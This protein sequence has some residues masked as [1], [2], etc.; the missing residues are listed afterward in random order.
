MSYLFSN[1][2]QRIAKEIQEYSALSQENQLSVINYINNAK[3]IADYWKELKPRALHASLKHYQ[4]HDLFNL[5]YSQPSFNNKN[6]AWASLLKNITKQLEFIKVK[7]YTEGD[8]EL[9]AL[10]TAR[11]MIRIL[12][13]MEKRQQ[14]QQQGQGQKQDQQGQDQ[15]DQIINAVKNELRASYQQIQEYKEGREEMQQLMMM[16]GNGGNGFSNDA[17]SLLK[18]LQSPD[19]LRQRIKILK[20]TFTWLRKFNTEL[21]ASFKK[22]QLASDQ[23]E[24]NR[25]EKLMKETQIT[26]MISG[27]YSYL[28]LARNNNLAKL[29][30]AMRYVNKELLVYRGSASPKAYLYIDKSGSMSEHLEGVPKISLAAGL[31]LAM[32]RKFSDT[33]VF[34]FDTE[35]T[36][37]DKN[38]IV[39]MLLTIS[40][41]GGTNI[42]EVLQRIKEID[43][44]KTIHI[45]ITDGVDEVSDDVINSIPAELRR[46]IVFILIE[47]NAPHWMENF[48]H[49][50]VKSIAEFQQAVSNSLKSL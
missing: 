43:D 50:P 5:F 48:R 31:G 4:R 20:D 45:V 46:R 14:G 16:L 37:V 1:S 27:E 12:Q 9:S 8:E 23:G 21:P 40:A 3:L 26:H 24:I 18:Y 10:M 13:E 38:K 2:T 34:A 41:D 49:H 22:S 36:E 33:R 39:Q 25:I 11:A 30:F 17:L 28:A 6:T 35:V 7:K 44:G 15:Q 32:L 42:A 19:D 47:A 29:L